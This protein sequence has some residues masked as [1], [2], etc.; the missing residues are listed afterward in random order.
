L[1]KALLVT[2]IFP[3]D[4]GGP[5][6]YIPSFGQFLAKKNYRIEV[7][8]L[9]EEPYESDSKYPFEITR[10]PRAQNRFFRSL[11]TILTIANRLRESDF[12][13][14]NGLYY[15]SAIAIRLISFRGPTLVKI[16]GDPVWERQRNRESVLNK[17]KSFFIDEISELAQFVERKLISWS[18]K[19]FDNV[20]APG[21]ELASEVNRWD[22][23]LRVIVIENGVSISD[24]KS[25]HKK[26]YDLVVLSRLVPWKN[27]DKAINLA[28]NLDCS[29]AII[30]DGPQRKTLEKQA[31]G[32]SRI[33]FLG[34][35]SQENAKKILMQ[36]KIF[37]QL[38]DYEGMS[39]SLLQAMA[40]SIPCVLSD[41]EANRKVFES[42]PSAAIFAEAR[43]AIR[44]ID[45]VSELLKDTKKQEEMGLRSKKI[46]Q[47]RFNEVIQMEKMMTLLV[48]ND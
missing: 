10:L 24:E 38:S 48:K 19:Q 26:I 4:I 37:C 16:V 39:F 5:A 8:T 47:S 40:T 13:F 11:K 34:V 33:H 23:K 28:T 31:Q 14:C 2:G 25:N 35:C 17:R 7:V 1:K 15:E 9:S 43:N 20:T 45:Q 21:I 41:I 46:V 44:I 32:N 22:T 3:P 18:L 12:L 36:S 27:I 30:G 6:T 29:L 42:D